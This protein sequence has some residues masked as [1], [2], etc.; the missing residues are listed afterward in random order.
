MSEAIG[1]LVLLIEKNSMA[2]KLWEE[3]LLS[4]A[5]ICT[6]NIKEGRAVLYPCEELSDCKKLR[7]VVQMVTGPYKELRTR[8]IRGSCVLCTNL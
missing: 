7:C 8:V 6:V 4:R 1:E 3:Q 5:A 2:L